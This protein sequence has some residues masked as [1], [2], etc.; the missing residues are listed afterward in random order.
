[1]AAAGTFR[2]IGVNCPSVHSRNRILDITALVQS[3][4]M[5]GHLNIIQVGDGERRIYRCGSGPPVS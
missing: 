4:G 3:V 1:M 5:M 2:M